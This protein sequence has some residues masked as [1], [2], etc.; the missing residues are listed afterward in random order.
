YNN[1]YSGEDFVKT[2]H[3]TFDLLIVHEEEA[4]K[5][6]FASKGK[7]VIHV[8]YYGY[9]DINSIIENIE[10]KIEIILE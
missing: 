7:A 4:M 6:V 10:E 3:P 1:E 5:E 8:R 9:A 2:R